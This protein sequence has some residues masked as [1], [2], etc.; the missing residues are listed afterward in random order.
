MNKMVISDSSESQLS[1]D[2]EPSDQMQEYM[3]KI[4]HSQSNWLEDEKY[5]TKLIT[6]LKLEHKI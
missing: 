6:K 1:Q 3:D 2:D 4:Q 5:M